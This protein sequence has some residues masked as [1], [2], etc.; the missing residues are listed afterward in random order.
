MIIILSLQLGSFPLL[1]LHRVVNV[2]DISIAYSPAPRKKLIGFSLS[3]DQ[4]F[5]GKNSL[6]QPG[7]GAHPWA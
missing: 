7:P 4:K 3:Q 2:L 6:A 5:T 1:Y